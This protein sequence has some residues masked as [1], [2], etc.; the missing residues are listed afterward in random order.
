MELPK[1]SI[2]I[3][4]FNKRRFISQ[5][6]DSIFSQEYKNL[7]VIIQDGAST[8]GTFEILRKYKTRYPNIIKLESKKDGGQL[9]A[10]NKGLEKCSGEILAFINAD[11]VY[12]PGSFQKVSNAFTV[13]PDLFWVVGRSRVINENNK[14]IASF[15]TFVKN[16]FLR[17]NYF[18]LLLSVNY[19]MQP[20]VFLS[21]RA[22]QSNRPLVGT[23]NYILEY[24]FWLKL[25]KKS[26][27]NAINVYLS[28]FR[29]NRDNISTV[30]ASEILEDDYLITKKYSNNLIILLLHKIFNL[31]RI[32]VG[33]SL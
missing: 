20:S 11:D 26:M 6:L 4:S 9:D 5:T 31:I 16:I 12:E 17:A 32:L 19:I 7:E 2:V 8:D 18:P 24:D 28:S 1:I 3:P 21:K 14:Q 25:A 23:K 33:K 22:Y 27:P 10:L 29:V 13:Q 15:V 30:Y